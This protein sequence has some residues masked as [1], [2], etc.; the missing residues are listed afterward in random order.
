LILNPHTKKKGGLEPNVQVRWEE[1]NGEGLA[2]RKFEMFNFEI[3]PTEMTWF[4]VMKSSR[5]RWRSTVTND[6]QDDELG[7]WWRTR[8]RTQTAMTDGDD[9]SGCR[10]AQTT[11][12]DVNR[13]LT[14]RVGSWRSPAAN[15]LVTV[16]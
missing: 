6:G 5:Q 11:M 2:R 12:A 14:K 13:W 9:D 16:V 15:S 7:R 8:W 3:S 10:S 4:V 1:T